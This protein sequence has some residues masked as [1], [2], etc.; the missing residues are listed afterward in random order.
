M[1]AIGIT[2]PANASQQAI[3]LVLSG[4]DG[5]YIGYYGTIGRGLWDLLLEGD[6]T[7]TINGSVFNV[8]GPRPPYGITLD[9]HL[10]NIALN[11]TSLNSN[12]PSVYVQMKSAFI[13]LSGLRCAYEQM[14]ETVR[15]ILNG[16]V[17][18]EKVSRADL[19]ADF[20]WRRG[21]K[22]RDLH[23]FI[24]RPK[25]KTQYFEG[26]ELSGFSFGKG[27]ARAQIYN[28][29]LEC[30]KTGKEWIYALWGTHTQWRS[31]VWRIEFQLRREALKRFEV[32]SFSS[33][34]DVCP[35]IWRY[36]TGEWLSM[37]ESGKKRADRRPL[38]AFWQSVQAVDMRFEWTAPL[39]LEKSARRPGVSRNAAI[40]TIAGMIKSFAHHEQIENPLQALELILPDIRKKLEAVNQVGAASILRA[41]T[42]D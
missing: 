31:P 5:I 14:V 42:R 17:E 28:K 8:G 22:Q 26:S 23:T 4:F 24:S 41:K 36:L 11:N 18:A 19:F 40:G 2:P 9:N 3:S 37:R 38:T 30:R 16:A 25:H 1:R 27:R 12:S 21:L 34:L 35:N 13:Q 29:S 7:L 20:I 33:L 10:M 32:E 6:R 15:R 39:G